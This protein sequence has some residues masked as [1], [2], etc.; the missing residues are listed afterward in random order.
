MHNND[1]VYLT[2]EGRRK[3]QDELEELVQ[4]R[5][6]LVADMIR[7]AK[8]AGDISENAG[9]DEAKGQQAMVEGRIRHLEELLA[10][11]EAIEHNPNSRHVGLGSH[12]TVEEVGAAEPDETFHIVGSAEA[13]PSDGRIS[14]ESPLGK[15]ILGRK[16]GDT[17]SYKTPGGDTLSFKIVAIQ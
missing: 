11:A 14:N 16:V 1:A 12:V 3:L 9:Y 7:D 4:V 8:E 13:S 15:A 17:V 2:N 5:R 10:R 6:P